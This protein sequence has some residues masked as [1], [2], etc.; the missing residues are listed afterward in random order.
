MPRLTI[1]A[2]GPLA[3]PSPLAD[4]AERTLWGYAVAD[5]RHLAQDYPL[6]VR[7]P[8]RRPGVGALPIDVRHVAI[9]LQHL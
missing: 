8:H 6:I 1:R 3:I 2:P 7:L 4:L 5:T 9:L